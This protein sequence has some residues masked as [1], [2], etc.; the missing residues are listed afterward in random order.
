MSQSAYLGFQIQRTKSTIKLAPSCSVFNSKVQLSTTGTALT[1]RAL[2]RACV[3]GWVCL[4]VLGGAAIY[5]FTS[6]TAARA[7]LASVSPAL[8][9]SIYSPSL[10]S[11]LLSEG[12]GGVG[13][14]YVAF[15]SSSCVTSR[16]RRRPARRVCASCRSLP[17]HSYQCA[18]SCLGWLQHL[19]RRH[20]GLDIF[21][22]RI[23]PLLTPH[24]YEAGSVL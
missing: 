15:A 6:I 11:L 3:N 22:Q 7:L 23:P 18:G 20:P 19:K 16:P 5:V 2:P 12:G 4:S 24:L 21:L 10:E 14:Q 1:A 8:E 13:K 17:V 9:R